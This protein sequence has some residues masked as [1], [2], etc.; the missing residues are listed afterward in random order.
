MP[1][2]HADPITPPAPETAAAGPE[3]SST[4]TPEHRTLV[5]RIV[6]RGGVRPAAP[7]TTR[8]MRRPGAR[9]DHRSA[10]ATRRPGLIAIVVILWLVIAA[11]ALTGTLIVA[12]SQEHPARF[13]APL[14]I[15]P[16]TQQLPGQCPAGAQGIVGQSGIGPVCYELTT[17]IT[18]KRV[19]DVHVERAKDGYAVSISLLPADGRAL[20]RLT[21]NAGGRVFALTVNDQIVA[22]PRVDAPITKGRV[23]ISGNLTRSAAEDIVDRLKTG[24]GAPAPAWTPPVPYPTPPAPSPTQ[25]PAAPAPVPPAPSQA[26]GP[27][28]G[29]TTPSS[30][31]TANTP[32]SPSTTSTHSTNNPVSV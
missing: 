22:A 7:S 8:V 9:Q 12:F 18:I 32:T 5:T 25:P 14:K 29:G 3:P 20:K 10:V 1:P 16:V 2:V 4:G 17:G 24:K 26:P 19:N 30:S 13:P 15:Y 27:T 6:R 23:L 21:S 28:Q 31:P 11:I